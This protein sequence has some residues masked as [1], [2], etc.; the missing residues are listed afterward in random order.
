MVV[1]KNL[2][3]RERV[4]ARLEQAL[5]SRFPELIG[6][7]YPLE[8]GMPVGWP[9]QY[10][11]SGPE[12]G[13]V[14]DIAYRVADIL[15]LRPRIT[16]YQLRLDGAGKQGADPGRPGSGATAGPQLRAPGAGA[17]H[18][19]LWRDGH[20]DADGIYLVDV[21]VRASAEQR[22]S[23]DT[24]R[25]L[26]IPLP[27]GRTVALGQ[28]ASVEYG[29]EYPIVWRRDRRPTLTVQADVAQARSGHGRA[30]AG[31]ERS[32]R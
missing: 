18:R 27:N 31:A 28:I 3:A 22:M 24:I 11:V 16:Q 32:R 5:E 23:L 29:Q 7:V 14:R 13:Q 26:Q 20:A 6:R 8:M 15:R 2:D 19:R 25:T 1:T 30:G 4:R 10:R 21:L 9:V 17:E 12:A